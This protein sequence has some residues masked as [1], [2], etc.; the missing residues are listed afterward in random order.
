MKAISRNALPMAVLR[1][2][3]LHDLPHAL[4]RP[5]RNATHLRESGRSPGAQS[6]LPPADTA[7]RPPRLDYDEGVAIGFQ[8]G[9]AAGREAQRIEGEDALRQL[10]EQAR[11]QAFAEGH[12]EGVQQGA[13]ESATAADRQQAELAEQARR[14]GD[15]YRQRLERA[16]R[17]LQGQ[18]TQVLADAEDDLVAMS[19]EVICRVLGAQAALPATIREMVKQLMAQRAAEGVCVHLHP[20]DLERLRSEGGAAQDV[21]PWEWVAD[22]KVQLGGVIVRTRQGNIDAR[23]EV[24]LEALRQALLHVRLERRAGLAGALPEP[25]G[26]GAERQG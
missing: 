21:E 24:Q 23:L 1:N 6:P 2:V 4:V 14:A 5:R 3:E 10:A 17:A 13:E 15:E 7:H 12:A 18:R 25:S 9:M 26:L 8:N 11:T 22:D 19:F 20:E 16:I